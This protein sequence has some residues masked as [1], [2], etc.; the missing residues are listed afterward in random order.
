MSLFIAGM[1]FPNPGDYAAA[2][3]AIFMASLFAAVVGA[4]IL[5]T[6]EPTPAFNEK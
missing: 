1:S 4:L 6:N 5:W 2:K 3:A